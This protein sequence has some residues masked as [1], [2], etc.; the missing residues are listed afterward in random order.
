ME[1]IRP[2]FFAYSEKKHATVAIGKGGRESRVSGRESRSRARS[3]SRVF[4]SFPCSAW[5]RNEQPLCG[6]YPRAR[7]ESGQ[8]VPI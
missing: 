3:G 8:S 1:E 6:D 7:R 5:E 4:T 2:N